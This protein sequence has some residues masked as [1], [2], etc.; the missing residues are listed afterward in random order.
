MPQA[1][2][3]SPNGIEFVIGGDPSGPGSDSNDKLPTVTVDGTY[4]NFTYRRTNESASYN[5]FV[6]YGG[7]L[8]GWTTAEGG[9][10]GVIVNEINDGFG[11]GIDS[12][13]VRIP[14]SLAAPG[15]S[16]FARLRVDIP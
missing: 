13:E 16:L 11:V 3:A 4:L 2:T 6:E 14:R 1:P 15:T 8:I 7:N 5:P 9:V 10:N 12:V